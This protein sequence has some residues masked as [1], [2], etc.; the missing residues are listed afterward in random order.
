ML[1]ALL[2]AASEYATPLGPAPLDAAT[3]AELAA[4]GQFE[5]MSHAVDEVRGHFLDAAAE[6]GIFWAVL[7]F[8]A[9]HTRAQ[10]QLLPWRRRM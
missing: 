5:T 7:Q 4:T 3:C 10:L 1:R 8:G 9:V 2:S 6:G